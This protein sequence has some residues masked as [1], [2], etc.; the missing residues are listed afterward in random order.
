[1]RPH[2]RIF[3]CVMNSGAYGREAAMGVFDYVRDHGNWEIQFDGASNHPQSLRRTRRMLREWKAEGIL[4]QILYGGLPRVIARLKIPAVN[5][6]NSMY[7]DF[8][9]VRIDNDAV[10]RSAAQ[11]FIGIGL[12]NFAF[13]GN[14]GLHYSASRDSAYAA[15]LQHAGFS[16]ASLNVPPHQPCEHRSVTRWLKSLPK[17]VGLLAHD[18]YSGRDLLNTCRKL[19]LRVPDDVAILGGD[20]DEIECNLCSPPLSSVVVPCRKIGYEAARMLDQLFLLKGTRRHRRTPTVLIAP[21]GIATRHS[22][23]MLGVSDPELASAIRYIHAH[24]GEGINVADVVAHACESRRSLERRFLREL[25]RTPRAEI[26]R[27]RLIRAKKLLSESTLKIAD[28]SRSCGYGKYVRFTREFKQHTGQT[29]SQ[30][31]ARAYPAAVAS[32]SDLQ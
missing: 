28:V 21:T 6:S 18:V 3:V 19:G 15:E 31:R 5:F 20:N 8:P 10:G 24:A 4:G 9:T 17:P 14:I 11:Y 13:F 7:T 2:R 32:V 1:M 16:C 29:P 22:T 23:D 27:A 25:G 30:F 26:I 12:R